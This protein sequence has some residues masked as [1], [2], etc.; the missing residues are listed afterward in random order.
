[1][2]IAL[3]NPEIA[4]NVGAIIRT[5][6]CFNIKLILIEPLGFLLADREFRRA[7]MDYNTEIDLVPSFAAFCEKY[8]QNKKILFT[9]HTSTCY[10]DI[11]IEEEDI[12]VFGRES[13]GVENYVAGYMNT[14]VSIPMSSNCR[15][16]NLSVS[17]A[18]AISHFQV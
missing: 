6:A 3:Y 17:V 8:K 7:K 16:L 2:I 11:K 15:S 10:K 13:D 18:I 5:C 4:S 1:M 12:L 9:P 14:L